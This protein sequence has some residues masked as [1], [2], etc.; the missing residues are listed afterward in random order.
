MM[1]VFP[2]TLFIIILSLQTTTI[3]GY[4]K[5]TISSGKSRSIFGE[6]DIHLIEGNA[7]DKAFDDNVKT[8]YHSNFNGSL[9]EW[10]AVYLETPASQVVYVDIINRYESN[11]NVH[12]RLSSDNSD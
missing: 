6:G 10:L 4:S 11:Y 12:Y 9:R 7:P 8:C 2:T 5:L 3:S 1:Y